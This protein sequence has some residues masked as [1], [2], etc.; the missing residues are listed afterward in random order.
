M[1]TEVRLT[2]DF[3][4]FIDIRRLSQLN[5]VFKLHT[6]I[7]PSVLMAATGCSYQQS[8]QI[9]MF[10]FVL[11]LAEGHILIYLRDEPETYIGK[12]HLLQG[13]P[14]F[15]YNYDYD[16]KTVSDPSDVLYDMEFTLSSKQPIHFELIDE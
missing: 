7:T 1:T 5:D 9:L 4:Y 10:I 3:S 11:K 8:F 15:P 6:K 12:R 14:Q 13:L 2:R 16:S